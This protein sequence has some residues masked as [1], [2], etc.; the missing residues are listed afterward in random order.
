MTV[1]ELSQGA[2]LPDDNTLPNDFVHYVNPSGR[3]SDSE[4]FMALQNHFVPGDKYCF[5]ISVEYGIKIGA[6][7]YVG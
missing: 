4:K 5:P 7:N 3:L 1:A 2:T 6:F